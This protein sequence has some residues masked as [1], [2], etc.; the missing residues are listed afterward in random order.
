MREKSGKFVPAGQFHGGEG[1]AEASQCYASFF[2]TVQIFS[3]SQLPVV[4]LQIK[5]IVSPSFLH[6]LQGNFFIY[7]TQCQWSMFNP[8][9]DLKIEGP[10]IL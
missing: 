10:W 3:F 6:R 9:F 8:I 2:L 5:E 4:N 1:I 7:I